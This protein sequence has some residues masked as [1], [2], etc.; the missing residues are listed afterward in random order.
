MSRLP[1]RDEAAMIMA[2]EE[3]VWE[4]GYCSPPRL[5]RRTNVP[6]CPKGARLASDVL[7]L[8]TL[9]SKPATD[10]SS[11]DVPQERLEISPHHRAIWELLTC[12]EGD[13]HFCEVLQLESTARNRPYRSRRVLPQPVTL[14][15]SAS[16][17]SR[18]YIRLSSED[19]T[20][21][22]YW[23]QRHLTR[24][25]ERASNGDQYASRIGIRH[26]TPQECDARRWVEIV[27]V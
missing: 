6:L 9:S 23:S 12:V 16:H 11:R 26:Y 21:A 27:V 18:R 13:R 25:C 22:R 3:H 15:S 8:V 17:D 10:N 1:D 5:W 19:G 4:C 2:F 7:A 24:A 20:R 14:P